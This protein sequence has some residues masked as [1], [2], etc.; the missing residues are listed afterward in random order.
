MR[1][2]GAGTSDLEIER[3]GGFPRRGGRL[4]HHE[5]RIAG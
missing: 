5:V 2:G 1:K 4:A 3:G